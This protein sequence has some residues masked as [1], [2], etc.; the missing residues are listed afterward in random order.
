MKKGLQDWV[1]IFRAGKHTDSLGRTREFTAA[2]LDRMVAGYDPAKHEAPAVV[3]HPK[4]NGPA[5][6][7]VEGMKRAGGLLLAKFKQV[8]PEFEEMV[9]DGR[10]K[11]RSVS[12]YPD[13]TLRHVGFLGAQP[14][15]V[16]GLKDVSFAA[17]DDC[18]QYE[19]SEEDV[20]MDELEELKKK[21]AEAEAG[22]AKAEAEAK[23]LREKAEAQAA[24]FAEAAKKQKRKEIA[25][26]VAAGVKEGK[27]LPAW[28]KNGLEE[29]MAHLDEAGGDYEFA[30]G[31]KQSPA[32]WFKGFLADFSAH[33]L[34]KEFKV[35]DQDGGDHSETGAFD[36]E[37]TSHV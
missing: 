33:P 6:G 26:F 25:E 5:Y 3:G 29:F 32:D 4:D 36:H 14:P 16:K 28:K 24:G 35:V 2:D 31:K 9:R 18:S 1:E 15:A 21:L 27:I 34:F 11:K 30:E 17:G 7:W 23:E 22:K 10:F 20:P 37:L 12:L 8:A 13:G 19:F